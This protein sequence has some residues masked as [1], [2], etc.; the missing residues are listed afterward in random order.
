MRAKWRSR[1]QKWPKTRTRFRERQCESPKYRPIAIF[2][3]IAR[4]GTPLRFAPFRPL[5]LSPASPLSRELVS[6]G[7]LPLPLCGGAQAPG[8]VSL[9][10]TYVQYED[11]LKMI[12][13]ITYIFEAPRWARKAARKSKQY[14]DG[15]TLFYGGKY[16]STYQSHINGRINVFVINPKMLVLSNMETLAEL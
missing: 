16:L 7:P 11:D 1:P 3:N 13:P 15:I 8:R 10:P 5:P 2:V 14:N 4:S 6:N 12:C 9:P